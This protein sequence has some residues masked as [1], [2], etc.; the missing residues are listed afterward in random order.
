MKKIRSGMFETN[1]SSEH[2]FCINT[3]TEAQMFPKYEFY[4]SND[5]TI[6]IWDDDLY[7]ERAPFTILFSVF[8]KTRYA[9]ASYKEERFEEIQDIFARA[10]NATHPEIKFKKFY[11]PHEWDC[12]NKMSI[13][14]GYIDH[15]SVG[16]LDEFLNMSCITLEEFIIN[17]KYTI[18]IDGDEYRLF[19]RY[20][21]NGFLTSLEKII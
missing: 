10:Y 13:D 12:D 6:A 15:Q 18:V 1:S 5:G 21:N 3:S 16:L 20:K 9:I 17:P 2:C 11:M 14:Y 4:V 7:F 8:D 19:D